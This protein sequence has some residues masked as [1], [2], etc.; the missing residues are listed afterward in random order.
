[1]TVPTSPPSAHTAPMARPKRLRLSD[2]NGALLTLQGG[3]VAYERLDRHDKS[4]DTVGAHM[5]WGLGTLLWESAVHAVPHADL[6]SPTQPVYVVESEDFIHTV[7]EACAA[8]GQD[9][10]SLPA[11]WHCI[12]VQ[13]AWQRLANTEHTMAL[14]WYRNNTRLL[15][16]FWTPLLGALQAWSAGLAPLPVQVQQSSADK[17]KANT[18]QGTVPV[19]LLGCGENQL[20]AQELRCAFEE[21]GYLV[22]EVNARL[23]KNLTCVL[24][25]LPSNAQVSMFFSINIQ[26]LDAQGED[27]AL[28]QALGIAIALWF[29]DNPWH[30]LAALRLPWWKK[31]ALLVTDASFIPALQQHGAEKVKHIPLAVA[32]HM[33]QNG[34]SRHEKLWRNNSNASIFEA[35]QEA[36]CIFVGRAAFPQKEQFFAAARMP[37][38]V[39]Q[40]A[41]CLLQTKQ[42]SS[43]EH[44][45]EL[46]P[47]FHW[48]AEQ[49][50]VQ[51]FWPQASVRSVGLGAEQ[52]AQYQR[53]TWLQ[54]LCSQP[55]AVFG[56]ASTWQQ[57]LPHAAPRYFFEAVD[58]YTQL[59]A[60]YGAAS[61]VLNV[62]SLLLPQGLTQRHFDV[63]AA[64]G[65]LWT[66]VT[67]GLAIF[68]EVL[69]KPI[70]MA[71]PAQLVQ[72]LQGQGSKALSLGA[73]EEL[74]QGWQEHLRAEHSYVQRV[75]AVLEYVL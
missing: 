63:W 4:R 44:A 9:M 15:P 66:N 22:Q 28:L 11:H 10:Q 51:S 65:F 40:K 58:Y 24:Q 17:A 30:V 43:H 34:R 61:S 42:E 3:A 73:K 70:S 59:P 41:Q 6:L 5:F 64:G 39:W 36:A 21:L 53:V 29:V 38:A 67:A 35:V 57:L 46:I 45:Q 7:T 23:G 54:A 19:I 26:G 2:C 48:W 8:I 52:S 68:P 20:L 75:R 1:M 14:W 16:E 25:S 13:E 27:A 56:D 55:A 12:S 72:C 69:T 47:D 32:Q 60:L 18:A 71:H 37:E 50:H 74:I 33:W 31:C 49:L 62:T